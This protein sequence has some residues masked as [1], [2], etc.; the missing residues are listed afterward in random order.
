MRFQLHLYLL[1]CYSLDLRG[2]SLLLLLRTHLCLLQRSLMLSK[3]TL[4]KHLHL[5]AFLHLHLILLHLLHLL[6]LVL[7]LTFLLLLNQPLRLVLYL[8]HLPGLCALSHRLV[9][10]LLLRALVV[11]A[12][13][14][15]LPLP[16]IRS[17]TLPLELLLLAW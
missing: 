5:H 8:L 17:P 12:L 16:L 6:H 2:R 9:P 15:P 13:P 10:L 14:L 4:C 3:L 11:K 1:C 7:L